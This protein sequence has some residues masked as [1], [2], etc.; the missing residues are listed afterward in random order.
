MAAHPDR[1]VAAGVSRATLRGLR[2]LDAAPDKTL[3]Y[4]VFR[5]ALQV[6]PRGFHTVLYRMTDRRL[7]AVE[8]NQVMLT[9]KGMTTL[10]ETQ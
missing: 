4:D 5:R 10:K 7:I 9:F 1:G 6:T 3:N 2:A 8:F